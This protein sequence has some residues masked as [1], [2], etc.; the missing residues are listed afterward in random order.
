MNGTSSD[1]VAL[2]MSSLGF[3]GFPC[4]FTI[5]GR[6]KLN[7]Y[8]NML[9]VAWAGS[10][11]YYAGVRITSANKCNSF[12]RGLGG[13]LDALGTV[14]VVDNERVA[15]TGVQR[16]TGRTLYA[17]GEVITDTTSYGEFNWSNVNRFDIGRLC[18]ATTYYYPSNG[19]EMACIHNRELTATEVWQLHANPYAMFESESPAKRFFD[20]GEAESV[21][22]SRFIYSDIF[23]V[24]Q[25]FRGNNL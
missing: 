9:N 23:P 12:T 25:L 21:V 15:I 6:H 18:A 14:S 20:L 3:I 11:S 8:S 22:G 5:I 10:S 1:Y 19:F 2:G 4:T 24:T 17:K 7:T 13:Q 16:T